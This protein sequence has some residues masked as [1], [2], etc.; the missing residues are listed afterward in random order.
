MSE[1]WGSRL[2]KAFKKSPAEEEKKDI[3]T[4]KK[5]EATPST[6]VN[7]PVRVEH[8]VDT[9]DANKAKDE[10]RILNL[11]KEITGYALTRLYE[12]ETEGKITKDERVQLVDKYKDDMKNLDT[13]IDRKQTLVKLHELEEAQA[14]L[15][16]MFH[17]KFG[18][19]NK[20]IAD[21]RTTLGIVPKE[22]TKIE[23]PSPGPTTQE[24]APTMP[25]EKKTEEK[26]APK[27]K[28]PP[29]TKAEEKIEAIQEE[30]MKVLER[31]EQME[32]EV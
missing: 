12:A 25:K 29:K 11:E 17:D 16:K 13:Q 19:I 28:T 2:K 15:V 24:T 20:N 3:T 5:E 10:L 7:I 9:K 32:T 31:L 23:T 21:V 22:T 27:T 1:S 14:S 4:E 30:V 18:E 8:T 6:V 26:A